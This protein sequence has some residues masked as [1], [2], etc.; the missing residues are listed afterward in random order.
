MQRVT[1]V[2][3]LPSSLK[4]QLK[5]LVPTSTVPHS[6][7]RRNVP[8]E[9]SWTESPDAPATRPECATFTPKG[10]EPG[11]RYPLMVWLHGGGADEQSLPDVMRHVSTRNYVAVAPR[12]VDQTEAGYTW[13]ESLESIDS[14]E[15]AVFEA[16]ESANVRFSLHPERVLL[17]GAGAGGTM[18]MRIALRHPNHFGGAATIDG[19]LPTNHQPLARLNDL[20][21]LP[22]LLSASKESTAYGESRVCQ[23]LALLHSG[24]CRVAIRQY[25]GD[26]D[27]TTTMLADLNR[28][29]MEIVCG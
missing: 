29:A 18:A 5:P 12:G 22:L 24:G 6:A 17:A 13:G 9:W 26:D 2:P 15:D 7:A 8:A 1:S 20:R 3:S 11:Y 28:W 27:L 19:P 21:G 10:F 23:D 4:V 16:I 14:A 25:P